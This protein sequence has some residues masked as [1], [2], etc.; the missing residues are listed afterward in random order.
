MLVTGFYS[1]QDSFILF[2][3]F[4]AI[5][6]VFVYKGTKRFNGGFLVYLTTTMIAEITFLHDFERYAVIAL[7]ATM[8]GSIVLLFLI[9]PAIKRGSATFSGHNI[10]ELL[11][12]FLGVGYV[13]F[14]LAYT[15]IPLVPYTSLFIASCVI[16]TITTIV[17]LM[18]PSFNKHTDHVALFGVAGASIAELGFAFIYEYIFQE[19]VFLLISMFMACCMKVI[20]ATYLL[21]LDAGDTSEM[22]N[23]KLNLSE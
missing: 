12:G 20:L 9:K 19:M 11:V 6:F 7:I 18:I 23:D 5:L 15:I 21:R 1:V 10:I 13:M 14:Y 8:I 16:T 22:S 4:A 17:C 3:V 2:P